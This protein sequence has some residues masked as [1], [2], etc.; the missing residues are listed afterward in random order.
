MQRIALDERS[1]RRIALG[2]MRAHFSEMLDRAEALELTADRK[3]GNAAVRRGL[4]EAKGFYGPGW[5]GAHTEGRTVV[6]LGI[7]VVT[8]HKEEVDRYALHLIAHNTRSNSRTDAPLIIFS[9]HAVTRA[10]QRTGHADPTKAL[11]V[12]CL[13]VDLKSILSEQT[14]ATDGEEVDIKT[15]TGC[16]H[17]VLEPYAVVCKTFIDSPGQGSAPL[18]GDA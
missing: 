4:V 18:G 7:T 15:T 14:S 12:A 9:G 13:G 11:A 6:A 5:V 1:A 8:D 3:G 10:Q 17:C 2:R 16:L